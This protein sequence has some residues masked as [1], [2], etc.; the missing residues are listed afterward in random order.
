MS[1]SR[2]RAFVLVALGSATF[3]CVAFFP[4]ATFA[5]IVPDADRRGEWDE[6]GTKFGDVVVSA[7]LVPDATGWVLRRT[8]ENRSDAPATLRVEERILETKTMPDARVEPPPSMPL[9]RIV[10]LALAPREK[11]VLGVRLPAALSEKITRNLGR[12]SSIEQRRALALARE[13][14][15]SSVFRETY[16]YYRVE[17]L[18]PLPPG[19]TAE[20]WDN[21][22]TEP[23]TM[24]LTAE[25]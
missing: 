8:A 7:E 19:A 10:T 23:A 16:L 1:S 3:T 11:R 13:D 17:Y 20:K 2:L 5:E 18:T 12:K 14:Y 15:Q 9:V 25:P 21:G 24:S 4:R 22:I 6:G